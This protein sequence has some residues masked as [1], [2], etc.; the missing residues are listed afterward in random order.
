MV[1]TEFKKTCDDRDIE[2][3][4]ETSGGLKM[5][6]KFSTPWIAWAILVSGVFFPF[7]L[8]AQGSSIVRALN[9]EITASTCPL[10]GQPWRGKV[11]LKVAIPEKLPTPKS[12][13]WISKLRQ[14][15]R[16]AELAK[17]Q[18]EADQKKF[19]L[20]I[21]YLQIIP[22][23][24][25]HIAWIS[26]LFSAYGLPANGKPIPV[27]TSATVLQALQAGKKLAADLAKNYEWLLNNAK[28]KNTKGV[29]N[30]IL[31]Q[32]RIHIIMFNY[33]IRLLAIETNVNIEAY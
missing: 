9:Q 22:Q 27:K 23:I 17:A 31:T 29:L 24:D 1:F 32:T 15:L 26:Q 4:P 7:T 2:I 33:A 14:T 21:P 11:D 30:L 28:D 18:Y 13:V 8:E 16:M 5:M 25:H 12:Q 3:K 20:T 10:C 6:R 19:G